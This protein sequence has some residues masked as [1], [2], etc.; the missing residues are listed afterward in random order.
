MRPGGRAIRL[1]QRFW[2]ILPPEVRRSAEQ[3]EKLA[4][5]IALFSG[6]APKSAA[7]V[8]NRGRGLR[9]S[10]A[11]TDQSTGENH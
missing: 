1:H 7:E 8:A 10:V 5:R 2:G 9:M 11:P 6:I 3:P 4:N